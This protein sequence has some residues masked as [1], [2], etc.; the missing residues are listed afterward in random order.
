MIGDEEKQVFAAIAAAHEDFNEMQRWYKDN[1]QAAAEGL[2]A[3][4]ESTVDMEKVV[5]QM[6]GLRV[7]DE[8]DKLRIAAIGSLAAICSKWAYYKGRTHASL[9]KFLQEME[10]GQG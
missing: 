8:E 2:E 6:F 1:R 10:D 4:G 7:G 9:P 5:I 3:T